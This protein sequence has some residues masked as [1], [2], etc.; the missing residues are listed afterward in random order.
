MA[1]FLAADISTVICDKPEK[2][3]ILLEHVE[4]KETPGL[5]SI[6]LMD[7]FEKEL[8]ERGKSC[9]VR[10]QTMQEVEVSF[11]FCYFFVISVKR[12]YNAQGAVNS[13][14]GSVSREHKRA[15]CG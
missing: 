5:R 7:P 4:R 9:G 10:I 6:I 14:P 12:Q 3:K 13:V 1:V 15:A 2:A 11:P 8:T